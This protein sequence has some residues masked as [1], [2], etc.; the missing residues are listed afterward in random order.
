MLLYQMVDDCDYSYILV[1]LVVNSNYLCYLTNYFQL[2]G[3]G[4]HYDPLYE[5]SPRGPVTVF[6]V[7]DES[8]ESAAM[9]LAANAKKVNNG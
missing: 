4:I 8:I 5:P 9:L 7:G 1:E 6:P 2:F 3:S